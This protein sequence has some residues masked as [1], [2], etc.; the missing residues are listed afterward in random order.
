MAMIRA[1]QEEIYGKLQVFKACLVAAQPST[2]LHRSN[3]NTASRGQVLHDGETCV[4][5]PA[6]FEGTVDR[7]IPR[8]A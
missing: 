3:E 4:L 6:K 8:A 1:N 2:R 5:A 7:D